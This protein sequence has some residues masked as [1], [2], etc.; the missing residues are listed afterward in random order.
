MIGRKSGGKGKLADRPP[1]ALGQAAATFSTRFSVFASN[2]LSDDQKSHNQLIV[3]I[4]T[5]YE[6]GVFNSRV[7]LKARFLI[8]VP[9]WQ[10]KRVPRI[11]RA[12]GF[13]SFATQVP[14][15]YYETEPIASSRPKV[16]VGLKGFFGDAFR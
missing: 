11:F 3:A 10:A 7:C 15:K 4:A 5:S 12:E 13:T 1:N 14:F 2:F 9:G 6:I 8:G 16:R